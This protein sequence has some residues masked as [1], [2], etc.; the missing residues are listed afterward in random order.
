MPAAI[1]IGR[2]RSRAS[3]SISRPAAPT[4]SAGA[5]SI[6]RSI[7]RAAR[8]SRRWRRDWP[9]APMRAPHSAPRRRRRSSCSRRRA[10]RWSRGSP[11]D[12]IRWR[13]SSCCSRSRGSCARRAGTTATASAASSRPPAPSRARSRR[14]CCRCWCSHSPSRGRTAFV[15][16]PAPATGTIAVAVRATRRAMPWLLLLALYFGWRIALFGTPFRVY[17]D[18]EPAAALLRGNWLTTLGSSAQWLRAALPDPV[19]ADHVRMGARDRALS[20]AAR[21][22]SR[23]ARIACAGSPLPAPSRSPSCCRC[24][25]SGCSIRRERAAGSSTLR[26]P[27]SRCWS[28]CPG[29]RRSPD[30]RGCGIASVRGLFIAATVVT[31]AAEAVLLH[32]ALT[33]WRKAGQQATQLVAELS[34][35][36]ARIPADGYGF[37]L[38]P[39]RIGGVPFGR[40]AQGGFALPPVQPAPLLSRL[41]VQTERDLAAWPQNMRRG[42][43]DALKRYPPR[44]V[45]SAV[46]AGQVAR[47]GA[48]T[49]FYCWDSENARLVPLALAA[50]IDGEHWLPAWK[51]ALAGSACQDLARA[52]ASAVKSSPRR[53]RAQPIVAARMTAPVRSTRTRLTGIGQREYHWVVVQLPAVREQPHAAYPVEQ[54]E[55]ERPQELGAA[56]KRRDVRAVDVERQHQHGHEARGGAEARDHRRVTGHVAAPLRRFLADRPRGGRARRIVSPSRGSG[57]ET[58]RRRG[59]RTSPRPESPRRPPSTRT[60]YS[61]D[62]TITSRIATR[63]SENEYATVSAK[64]AATVAAN[65]GDSA[66]ATRNPATP[67]TGAATIPNWS[68]S[69]PEANGRPASWD[70]TGRAERRPDR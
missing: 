20:S 48:P 21:G 30:S 36:P 12:S 49:D 47:D 16:Q 24:C 38:V 62:S 5:A 10:P 55:A 67:S 4:P 45:W 19:G 22:V 40:L 29:R 63:L 6:W 14:R 44:E 34:R 13:S 23:I 41:V 2:C 27:R 37:V 35:L 46:A 7:S 64:Y 11:G 26:P 32:A 61:S 59:A 57:T 31:V 52:P 25:R 53:R 58:C 68:G 17:P 69:A 33:T 51:A 1:T 39:D 8:W 42:I 18:S 60:V 28:H 50:P 54:D 3:R 70:A 43:V 56:V 66:A 9:P 65:S 15:R